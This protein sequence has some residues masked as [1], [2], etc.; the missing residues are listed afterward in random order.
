[1]AGVFID[2]YNY[3]RK[4]NYFKG[5]PLMKIQAARQVEA[6]EFGTLLFDTE[7]DPRQQHP[8]NDPEKEL[9]MIKLMTRLMR[10]NDAPEE[11]FERLGL[12]GA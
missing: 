7:T 5:A 1:M 9:E 3:T 2:Q 4:N 8:L 10:E 12:S 11:Q 6:H